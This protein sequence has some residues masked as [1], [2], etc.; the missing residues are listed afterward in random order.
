MTW[1]VVLLFDVVDR[2]AGWRTARCSAACCS[3]SRRRCAP[4]R[5]STCRHRRRGRVD[6][7]PRPAALAGQRVRGGGRLAGLPSRSSPTSSSSRRSSAPGCAPRDGRRGAA[8]GGTPRL[9]AGRRTR[10]PRPSASTTTR[11]PRLA[12]RRLSPAAVAARRSCWF[13]ARPTAG[14]GAWAGSRWPSP[15]L[16]YALGCNDGLGF[17]P[18]LLV[19]SPLVVVGLVVAGRRPRFAVRSR[20]RSSPCRSSGSSS[21]AGG[22]DPQW[23]GRYELCSGLLLAVVAAVVLETMPWRAAVAVV[24]LAGAVTR[25]RAGLAVG[26]EPRLAACRD[27]ARRRARPGRVDR[28][29]PHLSAGGRRLLHADPPVADRRAAPGKLP[30]RG[31]ARGPPPA[32]PPSPWSASTPGRPRPARSAP[33]EAGRARLVA[34][35]AG[36]VL[37]L[38]RYGGPALGQARGLGSLSRAPQTADT[39]THADGCPARRSTSAPLACVLGLG[40]PPTPPRTATR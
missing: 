8:A 22:A 32:P 1:G 21:T 30:G 18:G 2:R 16:C 3:A 5:S 23:G 34:F 24:A 38:T 4:R 40:K 37:H 9:V 10:S 17:L 31:P 13:L 14:P 15:R 20:S 35:L 29:G 6:G 27:G 25:R 36:R 7:P 11:C 19:A 12:A 33:T 39:P 28:H 26:A